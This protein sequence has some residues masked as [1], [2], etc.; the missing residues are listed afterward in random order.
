MNNTATDLIVYSSLVAAIMVLTRPGSQ[1]P[2]FVK[3]LTGGYGRIVQAE[4][5][6]PVTA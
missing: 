1:G 2:G 4:T 6:Q 3:A 5:G